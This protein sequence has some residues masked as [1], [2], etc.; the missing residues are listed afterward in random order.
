MAALI[1]RPTT[2]ASIAVNKFK[3]LKV[4]NSEKYHGEIPKGTIISSSKYEE[5]REKDI[6]DISEENE[7]TKPNGLKR[8][9]RWFACCG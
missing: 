1:R 5:I 3:V 9:I 2:R 6:P 7:S 8:L 4:Q